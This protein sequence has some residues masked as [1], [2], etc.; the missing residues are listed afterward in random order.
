MARWLAALK[1]AGRFGLIPELAFY[2]KKPLGKHPP[3]S[4]QDQIDSLRN[5][6]KECD[7]Q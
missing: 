7:N 4:F 6:E 1:M 5:L 2:F 3:L